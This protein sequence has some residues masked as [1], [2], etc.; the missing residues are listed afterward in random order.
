MKY[1][2]LINESSNLFD[3]INEQQRKHQKKL[4]LYFVQFKTE[5]QELRKKLKKENGKNSRRKLKKELGIVKEAY[6]ILGS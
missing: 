5:E 4:K 1:K 6:A 3:S 2:K